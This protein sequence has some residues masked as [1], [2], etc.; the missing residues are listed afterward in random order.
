MICTSN[1]TVTKRNIV[2][3]L[4]VVRIEEDVVYSRM[5]IGM[6]QHSES[7]VCDDGYPT[8]NCRSVAKSVAK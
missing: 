7:C 6:Y 8:F 1:A 3:K 2:Q 5:L 4:Q